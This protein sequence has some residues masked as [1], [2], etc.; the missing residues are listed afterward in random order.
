MAIIRIT[1]DVVVKKSPACGVIRLWEQI[2]DQQRR[3]ID[4]ALRNRVV[5][6]RTGYWCA[7]HNAASSRVEDLVRANGLAGR[8][9]AVAAQDGGAK[10]SVRSEIPSAFRRVG[11]LGN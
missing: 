5:G 10:A 4:H 11:N 6:E 7:V 9:G 8:I 2:L 3:R 1:R